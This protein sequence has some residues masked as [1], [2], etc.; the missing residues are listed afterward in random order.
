MAS[1]PSSPSPLIQATA[2]IVLQLLQTDVTGTVAAKLDILAPGFQRRLVSVAVARMRE[3]TLTERDQPVLAHLL[4]MTTVP[5]ILPLHTLEVPVELRVDVPDRGTARQRL[6]HH[7][8][9]L[10]PSH[11]L[12]APVQPPLKEGP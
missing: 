1:F 8:G 9:Q 10:V 3:Q 7:L 2:I 12:P 11:G 4:V 5:L 6:F